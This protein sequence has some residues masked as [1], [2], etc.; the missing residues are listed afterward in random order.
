MTHLATGMD[1]RVCAACALHLPG[2]PVR[3]EYFGEAGLKLPLYGDLL[4]VWWILE[5]E[6]LIIG[7]II[8]NCGL[9]CA[10]LLTEPCKI[11]AM[12]SS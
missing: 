3:I 4:L 12:L 11:H 2:P 9:V 10:H 7:T 1:T 5:L 6:A 8:C